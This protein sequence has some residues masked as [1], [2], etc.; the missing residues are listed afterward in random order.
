MKPADEL[1]DY[2]MAAVFQAGAIPRSGSPSPLAD[3]I[4]GMAVVTSISAAAEDRC[5][6]EFLQSMPRGQFQQSSLWARCKAVEGWMPLRCVFSV[7]QQITGGFQL[8]W[9][10]SRFGRIGYI[11]KG[12]VLQSE[13]DAMSQFALERIRSVAM[14]QKLAALIVQPPDEHQINA[15]LF[16]RHH[17]QP[18]RL[19]KMIEATLLVDVR[20]G[21]DRVQDR[22]RRITRK[23]I[24]QSRKRG[25]VVREGGPEI[26]GS[27]F[28]MMVATCARQKE[29]PNP[30]DEQALGEVWRQFRPLGARITIAQCHGEDVA[31][32]MTLPFGDRV[33]LWKKGW[34]GRHPELRPNKLIT[35]ESLEWASQRKY[36]TCDFAALDRGLAVT[37]LEGRRLTEAQLHHSDSFKLGFGGEPRLLPAA[38]IWIANP[39]F[40]AAYKLRLAL[41]HRKADA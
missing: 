8:L 2:Q 22:M 33:T 29:K 25:V 7:D 19:H 13:T 15:A 34:S 27:F 11:S 40:R 12:P 35:Y 24:R 10:R 31:G 26:I 5:W 38:H 9:R 21:I 37:L 4:E 41:A 39:I 3:R 16:P 1:I 18:N 14:E 23:H 6:D 30:P 32:Q 36:Q 20:G 17:F 28:Q